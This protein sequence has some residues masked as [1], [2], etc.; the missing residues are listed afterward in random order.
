MGRSRR[1]PT[2]WRALDEIG[3][4]TAPP[5]S[6]GAC[7]R[8]RAC[9]VADRPAARPDSAV[10]WLTATWARPS[11]PHGRLAGDLPLRQGTGGGPIRVP[12]GTI[13]M[14]GATT[15]ANH[16]R[17][18][19]KGSAGSNTVADPS[20][21]S[22]RPLPRSPGTA[23]L[24]ITVDGAGSSHGLLDHLTTL[25]TSPL[26]D[27]ALLHRL[28]PG[29]A[30]AAAYRPCPAHAGPRTRATKVAAWSRQGPQWSS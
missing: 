6:P 2:L 22:T 25:N 1:D 30:N 9:V 29:A 13:V 19:A 23:R 3:E 15:P 27:G 11:G 7:G 5:R 17:V 26:A 16:C 21:V 10:G 18:A 8:P 28:G 20:I 24:L 4:P 12:S 14:A